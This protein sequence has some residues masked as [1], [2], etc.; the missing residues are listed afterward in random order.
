MGSS[1]GP[2]EGRQPLLPEGLH[3]YDL[4]V[5]LWK[6]NPAGVF[7]PTNPA[8]RCPRGGYRFPEAAPKMVEHRGH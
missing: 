8:L 6:T 3:H 2:M 1:R 4:H 5:W 7:A